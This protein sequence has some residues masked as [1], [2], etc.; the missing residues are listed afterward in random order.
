MGALACKKPLPPFD[1]PL[2][3]FNC[4]DAIKIKQ[5]PPVADANQ[6][7]DQL[8][9][10]LKSWRSHGR[11]GKNEAEQ[12]S[13]GFKWAKKDHDNAFSKETYSVAY[14]P[15][16]GLPVM[17][18]YGN[19][20]AEP[21]KGPQPVGRF[22][23]PVILRPHRT[24]EGSFVPFVI[25]VDSMSWPNGQRAYRGINPIPVSDELYQ[26]MRAD[27]KLSPLH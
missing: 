2:A 14:R 24:P 19:W 25:F 6:A 15:A 11:T 4:P 8:A 7:I 13:P 20:G 3:N 17:T 22:A 18:K 23:S 1:K 27:P 16:L 12:N 5:L 21:A 10:W 9:R 26:A